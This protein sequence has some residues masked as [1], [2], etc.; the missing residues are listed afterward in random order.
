MIPVR[1]D[2]RRNRDAILAAANRLLDAAASPS[3]VSM[4]AIAAAAGVGKGTLFRRFGDRDGLIR[5]IIADR[6]GPLREAIEHG[7]A[8]LGPVALPRERIVAILVAAARL[9]LEAVVL[10]LAHERSDATSY[11][12]HADYRDVHELLVELLS[13]VGVPDSAFTAHA[14]LATTR[15]DLLGHLVHDEGWPVERILDC[16]R[17]NAMRVLDTGRPSSD[18]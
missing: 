15:A 10:N 4:D 13:E 12:R 17:G 18:H 11:Y 5:A 1:A 2:A 8:P 14:L 16:V 3:E 6:S 7:P 9:K